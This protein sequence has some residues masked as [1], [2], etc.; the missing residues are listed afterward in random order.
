MIFMS[1]KGTPSHTYYDKN[2]DDQGAYKL[3]HN[4][5][6]AQCKADG[7]LSRFIACF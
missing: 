6:A 7:T 1:K 5:L 2:D 3:C 4:A